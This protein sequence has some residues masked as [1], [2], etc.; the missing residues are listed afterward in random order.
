ML[1]DLIRFDYFF[2]RVFLLL[3]NACVL[4]FLASLII[5]T[6]REERKHQLL[7]IFLII[8]TISCLNSAFRHLLISHQLALYIVRGDAMIYLFSIP[9]GIHFIHKVVGLQNRQ[10]LPRFLYLFILFSLPL[11]LTPYYIWGIQ[12]TPYGLGWR[13][14]WFQKTISLTALLVVCYGTALLI[15]QLLRNNSVKKQ[16]ELWFVLGG[17]AS[18]AMLQ[19]ISAILNTLEIRIYPISDFAFIPML[20]MTYGVLRYR[21]LETQ[22]SW[23]SEKTLAKVMFWFAWM[24]P[25]TALVY[26]A[27]IPEQLLLPDVYDRVI[28]YGLPSLVTIVTCFGLA[29]F[30]LSA[31]FMQMDNRL[32]GI[33]CLL[34]GGLGIEML[35]HHV[36]GDA[37]TDLVITRIDHF[38]LVYQVPVYMHLIYTL[39][40]RQHRKLIVSNYLLSFMLM[41]TVPT[42]WYY[43]DTM[44][45]FSWGWYPVPSWG[46]LI[47]SVNSGVMLLWGLFLLWRAWRVDTTSERKQ[48]LGFIF[49][50]ISFVALLNLG[51]ALPVFG[52]SLY[53]PGNFT[54]LPMFMMAWGI[55]R[56]DLLKFNPYTKKRILAKILTGCTWLGYGACVPVL[57]WT[58]RDLPPEYILERIIPYGLPPLVS[59]LFAFTLSFMLLKFAPNQQE[60]QVFNLICLLYGFLNLDIF[61]NSIVPD[62]TIG[63]RLARLN[64][65]FFVLTLGLNLHLLFLLTRRKRHQWLVKVGYAISFMMVPLSQTSWYFQGMYRYE[66]GFFAQKSVLFDFMSLC[67]T[68]GIIYSVII[69]FKHYHHSVQPFEKHRT[70]YLLAGWFLSTVMLFGNIPA[71]HGYEVYPSGNFSFIPLSVMAYGMMVHN[72]KELLAL[73]RTGAY[74]ILLG[75]VLVFTMFFLESL[76]ALWHIPTP[77]SLVLEVM[78]GL[79]AYLIL[80]RVLIAVLN[81]FIP[82]ETVSFQQNFDFLIEL[83]S[84]STRYREVFQFVSYSLFNKVSAERCAVL[85]VSQGRTELSGWDYRSFQTGFFEQANPVYGAEEP[86]QLSIAHP[87]FSKIVQRNKIY[88]QEE[89]AQKLFLLDILHEAG[90]RVTQAEIIH[91]IYYEEQLIG[92]ILLDEKTDGSLFSMMEQEFIHQIGSA[93]GPFLNGIRLTQGLEDKVEER[94]RQ[95]ADAHHEMSHINQVMG[96][97]NSTLNIQD[98]IMA[99]MQSLVNVLNFNQ[100]G[101]FLLDSEKQIMKTNGYFGSGVNQERLNKIQDIELPFNEYIS[102]ICETCLNQEIYYFSPVTPDMVSS[103]FPAD[104]KFYQMNPVAS[105]L[106]FPLIIQNKAIGTMVFS[107]TEEPFILEEQDLE[108]IQRYVSQVASA[109]HN[110]HLYSQLKQ[111]R[112]QLAESQKIM[113]MTQTFQKFVPQQFLRRIAGENLEEIA[114]GVAQGDYITVL[115]SDIRNFT[116]FSETV[117][118]QELLNFLNA[119]FQ[120]MSDA[121][122]QCQGFIDKFIGD[123]IMALFDLP[124]QTDEQEAVCAIHAAITMQKAV[125]EYNRHRAQSGY[126]PIKTGIGIH[127][128]PVVI[129]TVGSR[130]RMDSTVLGDTVNVASRLE[131]LTKQYGVP[132]IV[133]G[134]TIKMI[135]SMKLFSYREIDYIQVRGKSEWV[136]IYEIF[137]HDSAEIR[138]LKQ[139]SGTHLQMGLAHRYVQ[140]W[141][142]A[143]QHFQQALQIYPEDPVANYHLTQWQKQTEILSPQTSP[144]P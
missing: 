32:F 124:D 79:S 132:I 18:N 19:I 65:F 61:L 36:L 93:L 63:L 26:I 1:F 13:G 66:W 133:S 126:H 91:P 43:Q 140:D 62:S 127:S 69:L 87:V 45:S 17:F 122:H 74:W 46:F 109:V 99:V 120:R 64:H 40:D 48:Q 110:A 83:L 92:V 68:G 123:A 57:W 85:A 35:F 3:V 58:L 8:Q 144:V 21:F 50:G 14:G 103:F 27:L 97:V 22:Q 52:I 77:W 125:A 28:H 134:H 56:H 78:A 117:T 139:K 11:V 113:A 105:Y 23:I 60:S 29:S 119:Y 88:F 55:F 89:I 33:T 73:I 54:F 108:R 115:F 135:H 112:F 76:L 9:V 25:L 2:P 42:S 49:A 90:D 15:K 67:W 136:T 128:G 102:Y 129:G 10:W 38:F 4:F 51:S 81:V 143:G 53:P 104:Y 116:G 121:I 111:T 59:F 137:D 138:E 142:S 44:R 34:W 47:F 71:M 100:C 86:L 106:L 107:H 41:C 30:C 84:Q 12:E 5:Q 20:L 75:I 80:K 31:G 24:A 82:P 118:P 131:S 16:Q 141:A 7:S 6:G 130:D 95:L 72:L 70:L 96:L 101:V 37:T 114:L 98:V 39:I 94:T